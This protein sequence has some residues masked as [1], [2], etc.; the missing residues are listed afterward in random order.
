MLPEF[1]TGICDADSGGFLFD[2]ECLSDDFICQ[3]NE[4]VSLMK[5]KISLLFCLLSLMTVFVCCSSP[6]AEKPKYLWV[7]IDAN[8]E[9]LSTKDSICF[10]LD[11][12]KETGFNG[13][14]VDVKGVEGSVLYN[15]DFI[16]KLTKVKDFSC[17]RDWDYLGYFIEQ[18][19][20]RDIS[21][22]VSAAIFPV[23]SP[24][25]GVG[26]V[27]EDE[28]L[29][30]FTCLEYTPS[31]MKKI[32]DDPSQVGAF[33]NPLLPE[34]RAYAL[35]MLEEIFTR[36]EFDAFCLD[37]CRFAGA[38]CDFSPATREAFEDYLG[39]KL[40]RFPEDVFSYDADGARVPGK[41]YKQWWTFRS[42]A[43][44]DFISEIRDLRDRVA[45][46]V[47]L[48][49]WAAS[50]LHAIYVNGQNWGS[51]KAEYYK[52]YEYDWATPDYGKTGFADLLD[53]FIT[54]TYLERIWGADDPESIEYGINRSIRDVM[55]D[56]SVHGSLYAKNTVE[57]FDEAVYLSLSRTEGLMV[58]DMIQ[59]V[60]N[61]LWNKIKAGIERAENEN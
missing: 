14:V 48:H 15:S 16:P 20:K 43:I 11:K 51:P 25:H 18:A 21:V 32:E 45:P 61:K 17:I 31:G 33:M 24:Y 9:R 5:R 49:Y 28:N 52:D 59:V 54:G 44:R 7:A 50:W 35:R 3:F 1:H 23:G 39:E 8:F 40:E 60:Q 57:D 36:Y 47:K 55:G 4:F 10:Y 46:E 42:M 37:Y 58:F 22:C 2:L 12:M 19:G 6:R 38:Q 53:V 30:K 27:Y 13:V 26:P 34:S 29:R 41:Y 56:C